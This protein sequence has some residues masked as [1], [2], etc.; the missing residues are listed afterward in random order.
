M[1]DQATEVLREALSLSPAERAEIAD[2]LRLSLDTPDRERVKALR[3]I[4][5]EDRLNAFERGEIGSIPATLVFD[6][7]ERNVK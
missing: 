7:L 1:S 4:E 5:A 2:R 6:Q 3:A